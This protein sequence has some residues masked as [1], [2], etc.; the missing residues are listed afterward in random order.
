MRNESTGL[1]ITLRVALA[2]LWI[3]DVPDTQRPGQ[4]P[5]HHTRDW[6]SPA[7]LRPAVVAQMTGLSMFC[8]SE[9]SRLGA[10]PGNITIVRC[11]VDR[12]EVL[13]W[14]AHETRP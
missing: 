8:L 2:Y 12:S 7:A 10:N 11:V 5:K 1:S 14:R 4:D 6:K 3:G 9:I 13:S